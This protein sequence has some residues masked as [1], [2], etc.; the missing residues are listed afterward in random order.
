MSHNLPLLVDTTDGIRIT[1]DSASGNIVT[2]LELYEREFPIFTGM[3]KDFVR[4]II[5]PKIQNL[6]PSSTR[7]GA[8]AFLNAIRRPREYVEYDMAEADALRSILGE[9]YE[10][11]LSFGEAAARASETAS[12]NYQI[13]TFAEARPAIAVIGDVIENER[14]LTNDADADAGADQDLSAFPAITRMDIESGARLLTIGD[15]EQPLRSY[16]LFVAVAD[17]VQRDNAEFFLQPH[18][19]EVVWGG[20]KALYIFQHHSGTFALYYEMQSNELFAEESGGGAY[21]TCTIVIKNQVYIPVLEPLRKKFM[22]TADA[23]KRFAVRSDL[24]FPD[25]T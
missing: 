14:R 9:Y 22:P 4:S 5:F 10:G 23:R 12:V 17:R 25:V 6:V 1:L 19:T 2:M 7:A 24:L 16:R 13:L 21:P 8:E 3:V 18:K 15:D 11:R 20:Q